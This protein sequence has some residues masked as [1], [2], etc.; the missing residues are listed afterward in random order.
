MMTRCEQFEV[1]VL[2]EQRWHLLGAFADFE[3][4]NALARARRSRVRLA[5]TEY[6]EGKPIVTDILAEIGDTRTGY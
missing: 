2:N 5:R 1:S 6:E 4:A 3:V